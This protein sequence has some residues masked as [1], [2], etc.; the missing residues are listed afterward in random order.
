[1]CLVY[2]YFKYILVYNLREYL[3]EHTVTE[4]YR[5]S[6]KNITFFLAQIILSPHE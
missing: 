6:V 4:Y 1:M 3:S 2:F 5:F